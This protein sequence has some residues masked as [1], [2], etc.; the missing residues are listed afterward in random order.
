MGGGRGVRSLACPTTIARFWYDGRVQEMRRQFGDQTPQILW[1]PRWR[2]IPRR[3]L[4][5]GRPYGPI[6]IWWCN[7]PKTAGLRLAYRLRCK[8]RVLIFY[9]G[10][11][12]ETIR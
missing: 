7:G 5:A 12:Y 3:W 8:L 1:S 10:P 4:M 2:W 9:T 6:H 11:L